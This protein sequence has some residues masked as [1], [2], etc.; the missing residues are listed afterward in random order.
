MVQEMKKVYLTKRET[1]E[2]KDALL[3]FVKRVASAE[4]PKT[5]E[6]VAVLPGM[7]QCLQVTSMFI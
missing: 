3:G 4:G 2:L 1:T 5:P 6:E 7:V